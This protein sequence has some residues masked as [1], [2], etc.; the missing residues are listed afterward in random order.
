MTNV[1]APPVMIQVKNKA[2]LLQWVGARVIRSLLRF[3]TIHLC[4]ALSRYRRDVG[5]GWPRTDAA[6]TKWT[7]QMHL[8]EVER[9]HG[10]QPLVGTN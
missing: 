1:W 5:E 3:A 7:G 6:S 9:D 8:V 4:V 10:A 2:A